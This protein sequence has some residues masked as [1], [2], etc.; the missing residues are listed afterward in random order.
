MPSNSPACSTPRP[1]LSPEALAS[2]PDRSIGNCPTPVKNQ[3]LS[4]PLSPRRVK[5]SALA[6]KMTLR[7]NHQR[8]EER[9]GERQ[10]VARDDGRAV[11]RDVLDAD[12][13]GP[14]DQPQAGPQGPLEKPIEHLQHPC[15]T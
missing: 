9:V 13:L 6:R 7:R 8:A 14:E 11:G 15:H 1:V 4:R 3:R 2:P 10:V 5:Y 12:H